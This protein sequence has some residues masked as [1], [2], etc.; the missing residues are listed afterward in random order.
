MSGRTPD[1]NVYT[2]VEREGQE[3]AYWM[4]IGA[5]WENRDGSINVSLD[6]LPVNGRLNLRTPDESGED[7]PEGA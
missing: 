4:R 3:K 6:A 7:A 1:F 2:V 5:G